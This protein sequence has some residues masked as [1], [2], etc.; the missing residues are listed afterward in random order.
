[1]KFDS[2]TLKSLE[3]NG[4]CFKTGDLIKYKAS[5]IEADPEWTALVLTDWNWYERKPG[6]QF[7]S[8]MECDGKCR[9]VKFFDIEKV[10]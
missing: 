2:I 9:F 4:P 6:E 10:G 1:M 8:V 3:S 7:V 5:M